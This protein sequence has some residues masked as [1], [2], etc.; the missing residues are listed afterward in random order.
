LPKFIPVTIETIEAVAK[1]ETG[2]IQLHLAQGYRLEV[3][4]TVSAQWLSTLLRDLV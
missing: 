1:E 4:T 3:P 2:V